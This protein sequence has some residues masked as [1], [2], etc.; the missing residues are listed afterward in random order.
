MKA[1][2][3]I[4]ALVILLMVA[5]FIGRS[6]IIKIKPGQ[7]GVVN[8]EWTS[9]FVEKD[10]GAG[11]HLDVG[12]FHN[13]TIFDSTVQTMH[14]KRKLSQAEEGA[15]QPLQVRTADGQNVFLDITIKYRIT[16]G[17]VWRVMK[18]AGPLQEPSGGYKQLA[19][20]RSRDVLVK[21]LG[22][23]T[24]KDFFSPASRATVQQAMEDDLS[25]VFEELH[26]ELIAI[27]LRD[28]RFNDTFEQGIKRNALAQERK[29]LARAEERAEGAKGLTQR[30]ETETG[31]KVLIIQQEREKILRTQTAGNE[32]LV[33]EVRANFEK[34]VVQL[35]SDADLYAAQQE[36]KAQL[37]LKESEAAGQA[38][39]REAIASNGGDVLVALELATNL[40]LDDMVVSTQALDPLDVASILRKFGMPTQ[41]SVRSPK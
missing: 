21:S 14:F 23:I 36:A 9:G 35:G 8:K 5:L 4:A 6:L 26:V 29:A 27:L 30:I 3:W 38:L 31:A 7:V 2:K 20:T 28:I 34:K 24:T 19:V 15:A 16:P 37:L 32:R 17:S 33:A 25:N 1:L 10:F 13:W 12:P 39:M 11:Y 22:G 41:D 18:R 40:N